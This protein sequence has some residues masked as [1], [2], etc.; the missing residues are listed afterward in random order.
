MLEIEQK[1]ADADFADLE[2]RL[3]AWGAA[4]FT[5]L[6][7]EDQYLNAPDRDF[8]ITGEAFRLRRIG[9]SNR[10]TYKGPRLAGEVK[11]RPE[12]ELSLPDGDAAYA[13]F[14][15][16]FVQLGYRPVA[17]VRKH[18]R[19]CRLR[20]DGHDLEI[21]L[22]DVDGVGRFAEVEVL[23]EEGGADAAREVLLKTA[24]ELGL[25]KVEKR[26]YLTMWLQLHGGE[27]L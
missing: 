1:Y 7:E 25:S 4:A 24:A 10:I 20:R 3:A 2:R 11:M 9:S 21:C 12:M 15:R 13:D 5:D 16:L 17:V 26:A 22:D 6:D 19:A 27:E 23:A 18:R 8:R 14:L